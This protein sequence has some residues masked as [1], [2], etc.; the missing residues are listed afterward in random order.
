MKMNSSLSFK[1]SVG[2][3]CLSRS[4]SDL[5]TSLNDIAKIEPV[6]TGA[7]P[8]SPVERKPS[9]LDVTSGASTRR[10]PGC[11]RT[12]QEVDIH[13]GLNA[14]HTS[15][16]GCTAPES[17]IQLPFGRMSRLLP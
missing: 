14:R 3:I 10:A 17:E 1:L 11:Y 8:L 2:G 6:V 12:F 15:H 5:N 16:V 4:G 13:V 9:N 7:Y